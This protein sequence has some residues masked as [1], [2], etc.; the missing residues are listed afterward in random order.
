M[1]S[2]ISLVLI[3]VTLITVGIFYDNGSFTFT[4]DNC[5]H[6]THWKAENVMYV[7]NSCGENYWIINGIYTEDNLKDI[8]I[9]ISK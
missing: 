6:K 3:Y 9:N 5:T 1:K 2:I 4:A 8:S 7:E